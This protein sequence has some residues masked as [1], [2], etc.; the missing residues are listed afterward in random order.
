M[1]TNSEQFLD[2]AQF[3]RAIGVNK[4]SPHSLFIG[5]GASISSGIKSAYDCIWEWKRLIFISS[6]PGLEKLFPDGSTHSSRLKIQSWLDSQG[7]YPTIDSGEEYTFY[8]NE[9]F[10]IPSTR[11]SFFQNISKDAK[12]S[13]GYHLQCLLSRE[14]IIRKIW[15]TNFD[16]LVAKAA[17]SYNLTP[18]EIGLD[19][20]HRAERIFTDNELIINALHGDYRYDQLKNTATEL[21]AQ[22]AVL[23][24]KLVEDTKNSHL[25][26]VGFSGSDKSIMEALIEAYSNPGSGRLY[27]CGYS[28]MPN[29]VVS[30]LLAIAHKSK[31][32]AF[33]VPTNGFDDLMMRLGKFCLSGES[34]T[35]AEPYFKRV[36]TL[37]NEFTPFHL[38]TN[39]IDTVIKS[40][41]LPLTIPQ[42]I[43][44]FQSLIARQEGA[45]AK[46]RALT[47]DGK[48]TAGPVKKKILA[49]GT[50]N[51]ITKAFNGNIEGSLT[52][53]PID[54][55]DLN[56]NGTIKH[57]ITSALTLSLANKL[58]FPCDFRKKIWD[59]I[60]I[61]G[62]ILG[63]INYKICQAIICNIE[64]D[65]KGLYLLI[66]P[67]ITIIHPENDLVVGKEVRQ[68]ISKEIFDKMYNGQFNSAF[69]NWRGLIFGNLEAITF[70]F[71]YESGSGF[72]FTIEKTP[73]FAKIEKSSAFQ[74]SL[75]DNPKYYKFSGKQFDEPSL[76]FSSTDG[77][78]EISDIHPLRGLVQNKPYDFSLTLGGLSRQTMLGVICPSS[79]SLKFSKFLNLQHGKVA[80][81]NSKENYSIDFP[82]YSSVYGIALNIPPI[83]D[84]RWINVQPDAKMDPYKNT[85]HIA[86]QIKNSINRI[87]SNTD[88]N[89]VVIYIPSEWEGYREY[90]RESEVFDLH[91][92]IKAFAVQK[93][94]ATQFIEEDTVNN[95][96]QANRIHWW[97]SLSFYTKTMRTPWVLNDLEK[98]VAFAGIGYSIDTSA[99]ENH[100]VMGCSHIYNSRGE[101]LRY[102]LAKVDRP[103]I[104]D[105]KPHLS[106]SDAYQFG[107]STV[108]L[109]VEATDQLPKR[110]VIHK[111]T[112][113]T[114]E[115]KRGILD[116][117]KSIPVV[118]LIEINI[119]DDLRF[120]N[121]SRT[122]DKLEIDRFAVP[123]GV[124]VQ[125]NSYTALL[126]T[127]GTTPSIRPQG[128]VDFMGGRGIPAPLVIK[129]H[130]GPSSLETIAKEILS[131][132]KMNWNSASLYSKL[133]A[134]IQSSN[135]IAKIGSM[136]SRFSGKSYDYRLF[137]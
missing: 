71:P 50:L 51:D 72:N 114:E 99:D 56:D 102:R 103:V 97:L 11:K 118:D 67:S 14:R 83:N 95:Y 66:K 70:G 129:K 40:N 5:A 27:W 69:E 47:S 100:I 124:C 44:Q 96:S 3:I 57:I 120:V 17:A 105:K 20:T 52:R 94:I 134:T 10:P 76:L 22:D 113:F 34:Y 6:N 58:N 63:G 126:Y 15:T 42:D 54:L 73:L 133:P 117:L 80:V 81:A 88:V 64:K 43:F 26:I 85:L 65:D 16:H 29:T 84:L 21:Q 92:H 127:H 131:L 101:G 109:F 125:I 132:T 116:G 12:P 111:R 115:E 55:N 77:K 78:L 35:E 46:I 87:A 121:S 37:K 59:P 4:T 89:L 8:A 9:A 136:L 86:D 130:Y 23:R 75:P 104:L 18:I 30:A 79:H 31:R 107:I 122:Q 106:Y 19:T 60:P 28:S 13:A 119:E 49:V 74:K 61:Q 38:T 7:K 128:G 33:Y 48:V 36:D 135:D 1:T 24:E 90:K 32:E 137:I 25:I 108:Q 98:D 39:R 62:K 2:L 82:G 68:N 91:D 110:V 93:G 123:R 45:W 112:F 41:L 53:I